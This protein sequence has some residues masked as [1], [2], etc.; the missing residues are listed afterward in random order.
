M[1]FEVVT[2][3]GPVRNRYSLNDDVTDGLFGLSRLTSMGW[4]VRW[5]EDVGVEVLTL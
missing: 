2:I 4:G 5:Y 1:R 3:S